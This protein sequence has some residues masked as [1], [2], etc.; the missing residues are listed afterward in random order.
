[1][2]GS[3]LNRAASYATISLETSVQG[4]DP[5]RLIVLLF[6][7]S[8]AAMVTAKHHMEAGNI[9]LKGQA[10]SKAIDIISNGLR[11]SLDMETGGDLAEKL[12][13]LYDYW[14]DRLMWANLHNDF[15][16][17]DEVL[18]LHEEIHS[19]WT[20]IAPGKQSE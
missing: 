15:A 19:A 4:A 17:I 8:R 7:G 11:A 16:A 2:F 3:S 18:Q 5:H 9:P 14:C 13:A 12:A 1:M 20:E 10:L 6:E